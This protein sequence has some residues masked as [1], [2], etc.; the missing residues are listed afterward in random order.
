[1][2][3][4][5][6]RASTS[7]LVLALLALAS[8]AVASTHERS[9]IALRGRNGAE[10]R[11][12]LA[13]QQDSTSPDYHRWLTPQEFGRRF[14]PL[15]RDLKRVEA[16]LRGEGCRIHRSTGR[17]GV[18]CVGAR[19]GPAPAAMG[20]L[21]EDV[22]DLREP[23]PIEHKLDPTTLR[24]DSVISGVFYFSPQEYVAFYD[25][26]SL[27][28]AGIDG[29]GQRIGIVGTVPVDP[30]DIAAFRDLFG[31]PPLE[32]EQHGTPPTSGVDE[33]DHIE[34]NLDVSWSGAVAPGAAV[35]MSVTSGTL[36]DAIAYLVDR[37]DVSVMSLSVAFVPSPKTQPFIR[38]AL[39]LFRQAA[40]EG[41][42]VLVASGDFGALVTETPK[43]RRGVDVF[44][45]SPFVTGVG[46]T[47]PS[48]TSPEGAFVYGGEVVWQ[49]GK[50]ASGGGRSRVPAPRWQ[51]GLKSR[52][53]TVPDVSLAASAVYPIPTDGA[54][55]CCVSGTSAGAP[56]WA[57]IAAML[58]QQ[59]AK[60][61]GLLN[62][63]LYQLGNAQ[64][65]GGT[66][67]F[68]DIV[69][70]SSTTSLAPGF[71]ARKGYDLATG[72]GSPI[73]SALFAAFP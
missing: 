7:V 39:K 54:V 51:R 15:P 24:P 16:W 56:A 70:G 42:T 12:L 63:A 23:L 59:R 10:L 36:I 41:Q 45:Q 68:H 8:S 2:T 61:V 30:T 49:D 9:L 55:R 6:S 33:I 72:W 27:Q 48:S 38:H 47:S 11:A 71:P 13:A 21:V 32:L 37:S 19:P 44:A 64:V 62:P 65:K 31:L 52:T 50:Q 14:G 25:L 73:G 3:A 5:G 69:E 46:G 58:D 26:A 28:A 22:L 4:P 57:G 20:P 66:V 34:A 43:I 29:T 53:R 40:A 18:E 67:V 60:R 17:Q 35:V 1:M